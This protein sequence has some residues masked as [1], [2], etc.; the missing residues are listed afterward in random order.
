MVR[1]GFPLLIVPFV[2][3]GLPLALIRLL[4]PVLVFLATLLFFR[5]LRLYVSPRQAVVGAAMFGLYLPFYSALEHLH[6][7]T[8]AVFLVVAMLYG[9]QRYLH[10]GRRRYLLAAGAALGW[11][12][13]TRVAFGW[14]TTALLCL[15]VIW[16]ALG[17]TQAARRF[18]AVCCVALAV[19]VPWLA[20]TSSVT[21]RPLYWGSSGALSLYWMSSPS[22]GERGDWQQARAVFA[23][24]RLAPHRPFFRSLVGH[25]LVEQN[26]SLVDAAV[27]NIRTHP[28]RYAENVV[29]NL[30][31]MWFNFPYS[32]RQQ[33]V[34]DLFFVL[35]NAIVLVALLA[36]LGL[37]AARR[38]VL[39]VET[40]PFA[41][42]A[43]TTFVLHA[44]LAA[45]PRMLF[46]V[47]P[48]IFWFIV[49][50]L[51]RSI[52]VVPTARGS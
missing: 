31:R 3:L 52:R 4:G 2:A 32:F 30:S 22:P 18:A 7:E 33:S 17:R 27:A 37:V 42:F 6:S 8:L 5:L 35:P 49:V 14:V 43:L 36:S 1:S 29:A 41:L 44:L 12:A 16:W 10:E 34:T 19:C 47:V 13:L 28:T 45:Y 24:E 38:V 39:P 25:P 48:V 23:D 26:D 40:I 21:H 9:T 50:V 11:L 51:C 15:A 20:Y 46:P